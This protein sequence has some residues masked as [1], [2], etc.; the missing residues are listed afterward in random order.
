MMKRLLKSRRVVLLLGILLV[1]IGLLSITRYARGAMIAYRAMEFAQ[2][3]NFDAGN[4]DLSL[5]RPW[6]NIRYVA[7]AYTVPQRFLFDELDIPMK[8]A[9][10]E[11]PIGRL[12]G[13]LHLGFNGEEPAMVE[14]V[15]QAIQT[16]RDAPVVTGLA[17]G[18]V[19][20]W[21]NVQYIANS[22]G[23][24]T[25]LIFAEIGIP[26]VGYAYMPLDRLSAEANYTAGVKVLTKAIQDAVD[27]HVVDI[28]AVDSDKV[29]P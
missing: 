21:M 19:E 18:K 27:K 24:P 9:N 7:E 26:M 2:T 23:I 14:M 3:N 20:P 10:S 12:N 22:T 1:G 15:R 8:L 5:I 4:P 11:L 16:Y 17:E 28:N 13:R 25:A 29:T 6:M